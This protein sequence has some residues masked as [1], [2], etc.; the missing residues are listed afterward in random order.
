VTH[1]IES[2]DGRAA[3]WEAMIVGRAFDQA[4]S[5]HNNH[6][7]E[8]RGEEAVFI[9][10][11]AG[12]GASD[13]LAPHFRGACAVSLMQGTDPLELASGVFG[14]KRSRSGGH[15]RGDICPTPSRQFIGMFSGSLGT[16]VAY[17]TGAALHLQRSATD[18]VAICAFGDG[19]ANA[20]I[21]AESMN[22]AAMLRLPLVL[23]CQNNQYATSLPA[24]KAIAGD[25][26]S[27]R[28]RAL[29]MAA[30]DIDGNDIFSVS[31]AR[32]TARE[33]ALDGGGPTLIHAVTY[34]LGGHYMNDP[35]TYRSQEEVEDWAEMDP[36]ARF[37]DV[38]IEAGELSRD[39]AV[40]DM[41]AASTR[42]EAVVVAAK[43]EANE[44]DVD[45]PPSAF[46]ES[47]EHA[48]WPA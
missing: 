19:T 41:A 48:S 3:L 24:N 43:S 1:S 30:V 12:M 47:W 40:A 33:R 6:W 11:F 44:D 5:R 38:L 18:G 15:W 20:G 23:I 10:G 14:T 9:G 13:V 34:R 22:L 31:E 17:A 45:L 21:V 27:D 42:M 36:I 26:V 7:H 29:G 37:Q 39:A 35:E 4:M 8:A 28:A 16:T 25:R 32:N 46:A 2:P